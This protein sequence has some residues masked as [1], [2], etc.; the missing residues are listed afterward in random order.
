MPPDVPV[1]AVLLK[2]SAAA[3][4]RVPRPHR[5]EDG[6]SSSHLAST[7]PRTQDKT[8]LKRCVN[9]RWR[10][11]VDWPWVQVRGRSLGHGTGVTP[12][13]PGLT[14]RQVGRQVRHHVAADELPPEVIVLTLAVLALARVTVL[15]KG[16][17]GCGQR[18]PSDPKSPAGMMGCPQTR[19]GPRH[20]PTCTTS[21]GTALSAANPHLSR[22]VPPQ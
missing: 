20:P 18:D 12:W 19:G 3:A 22:S 13:G 16:A 6:H 9:Y 11:H 2:P 8:S 21:K 5:A 15:L 17:A 10:S 14:V 1:P 4:S 7:C